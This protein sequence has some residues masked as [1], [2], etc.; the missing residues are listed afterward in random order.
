MN[1]Q[2]KNKYSETILDAEYL[3]RIKPRLDNTHWFL[4][5]TEHKGKP[6]PVLVVKER[7]Y[8]NGEWD[9]RDIPA[10]QSMLKERGLI[11][12]Q[13]MRR[14]LPV[15]RIITS[16][17]CDSSGVPLELQ[18]FFPNGRILFRGNLPLNEE[19]GAKLSLIF[20]LQ[21]R[22]LDMD[23]VEL[24]AWRIDRFSQ[25]E[26]LYWLTRATHYGVTA[27]RW[28]QAG[29]RIMLGGQPGDKGIIRTLDKMRR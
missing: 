29:M 14:C 15:I 8:A 10:G 4:R 3:Q 12:G 11:Y 2:V 27:S 28:A 22:I 17:V 19:A 25:E 20:K 23:R 7:L 13:S 9:K 1:E 5:I 16:R 18:R 6:L 26:A 24:L 21:E